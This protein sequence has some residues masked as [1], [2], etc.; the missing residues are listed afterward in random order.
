MYVAAS[1]TSNLYAY[2]VSFTFEFQLTWCHDIILKVQVIS[3]SCVVLQF[4]YT[5]EQRV[6]QEREKYFWYED[7][8]VEHIAHISHV[9][10]AEHV[11][12]RIII[13]LVC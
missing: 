4:I 6:L 13:F 2:L 12:K 5:L 9:D 10:G 1:C 11:K 8:V 7:G 3:F